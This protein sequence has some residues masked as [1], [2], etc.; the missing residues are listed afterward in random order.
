MNFRRLLKLVIVSLIALLLLFFSTAAIVVF[1]YENEVK[2]FVVKELNKQLT[3]PVSVNEIELSLIKKFPN[4]S[5]VFKHVEAGS[6]LPCSTKNKLFKAEK[7]YLQFNVWDIFRKKYSLKKLEVENAEMFLFI[8]QEGKDNFHFWKTT[9]NSHKGGFSMRLEDIVLSNLAVTYQSVLEKESL[10]LLVKDA[11]LSGNFSESNYTIKAHSNCFVDSICVDRVNYLKNKKTLLD[12]TLQ[13][14]DNDLYTFQNVDLSV[15]EMRFK[16]NGLYRNFAAKNSEIDLKIK[17]SN[18]E[19]KSFLSLLPDQYKQKYTSYNSAGLFYFD[20]RIKGFIG[21]KTNPLFSASFGVKNA[22]VEEKSS[23]LKLENVVMK[24]DF[25]SGKNQEL[26]VEKFSAVIDKGIVNGSFAIKNFN[27]PELKF[28]AAARLNLNQIKQFLQLDTMDVCDGLLTI[29]LDFEGKT[30]NISSGA[31][32]NYSKIKASGNVLV[33]QGLFRLVGSKHTLKNISASLLFNNNDI[34]INECSGKIEDS[35]FALKGFLKNA[36]AASFNTNEKLFIEASLRSKKIN[37]EQLLSSDNKRP[38]EPLDIKLSERINFNL[39]VDV[40]DFSFR[41][42]NAY[43]IEGDVQMLNQKISL[44]PLSFSTMSGTVLANALI[45]G[46]ENGV[47]KTFCET[48]LKAISITQLFY[49][50]DNFGGTTLTDKNLKGKATASITF[51]GN[52]LPSLDAKTESITA[53]VNLLLEDGALLNFEPLKKLSRFIS[54]SEL[55]NIRFST[56]QNTLE[57]KNRKIFVPKM[58]INSSALNLS[59]SG[60]HSFDNVVDYHFKLLLS[61]LLSKKAKVAKS[62]NNEFGIIEED[63][64][65]INKTAIYLSMSG[66]LEN[67]KIS[68]DKSG[69]KA[70]WKENFSSEKQKIKSI[71]KNEFGWFK[72][73]STLKYSEPKKQAAR[74]ETEWEEN[75]KKANQQPDLPKVKSEKP[76]TEKNKPKLDQLLKKSTPKKKQTEKEENT[77]DFN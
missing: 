13:V 14:V 45:D 7:I 19:I 59:L 63:G 24:G 49:V 34:I 58:E 28:S 2:T 74:F 32:E 54:L 66:P 8:D 68:Y 65:G 43:N 17:G 33:E 29:D 70:Q 40:Q 55:S 25:I 60:S 76:E 47:L 37:L 53:Q 35:D 42:F 27:D 62:E 56:L 73:D 23:K 30:K 18:L 64:L 69:L 71:L 36:I 57:I 6:P 21:K 15:N 11:V 3:T 67:P 4:A 9:E 20:A 50:F 52:F 31:A 48:N 10:S 39:S 12:G 77:D 26:L 16:L 72:K 38:D 1:F 61:E 51:S 46:T 75:E 5:L 44:K 22:S 41:K